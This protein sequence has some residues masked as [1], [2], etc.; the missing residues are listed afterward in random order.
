MYLKGKKR[1]LLQLFLLPFSFIVAQTSVLQKS[2]NLHVKNQS[3]CAVFKL[4]EKQANVHF[5]YVSGTV[6]CNR[7][8]SVQVSNQ[9]LQ[10][11][12]SKI[13]AQNPVEIKVSEHNIV[14]T[15]QKKHPL[16]VKPP[17]QERFVP[18]IE[19]KPEI[20]VSP[21]VIKDTISKDTLPKVS[22]KPD[23]LAVVKDTVPKDT[24]PSKKEAL[25]LVKPSVSRFSIGVVAG[26]HAT[27]ERFV[28][29]KAPLALYDHIKG[30]EGY[31]SI[32]QVG[33]C[34]KYRLGVFELE[35]GASL[36]KRIWTLDVAS[37]TRDTNFFKGKTI[38][39]V[40]NNTEDAA[41]IEKLR[42]GATPPPS[43]TK[44]IGNSETNELTYLSIPLQAN[45][46]FSLNEKWAW[47]LGLG[48]DC[49]FLLQSKGYTLIDWGFEKLD[50]VVN[51]FYLDAK[52]Q[53][54]LDYSISKHQLLSF[55]AGFTMPLTDIYSSK[56]PIS[57]TL[58]SCPILLTYNWRF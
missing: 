11:V 53:A 42:A 31:S 37:V 22:L 54:G 24:L 1:F 6:D 25:S 18:A 2:I 56:Y 26:Y 35:T 17:K 15:P 10:V 3:V 23:T 46:V 4:I 29:G 50:K 30:S 41:I 27:L 44:T 12:V 55:S 57:R 21:L 19:K 8:V 58:Y 39:S 36:C 28:R 49:N 20:P 43:S 40:S 51:P 52:A 32:L 33:A 16:V 45:Y 48:A 47:K 9:P 34:V 13:M 14:L 5:V 7:K 38:R